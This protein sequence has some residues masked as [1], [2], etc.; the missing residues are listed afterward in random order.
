MKKMST[1]MPTGQPK[2][3]NS[4]VEVPCFEAVVICVKLRKIIQH[5]YHHISTGYFL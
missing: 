1:D 4:T 3:G 2:R 5:K